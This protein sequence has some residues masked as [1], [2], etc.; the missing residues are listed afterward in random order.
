MVQE[1]FYKWFNEDYLRLYSYHN[2]KEAETHVDFVIKTSKLNEGSKIL[3]IGCGNGR[4]SI[5][6]AKRGYDVVGVDISNYLISDAKDKAN[7]LGIKN[8]QFIN[9]D[10]LKLNDISKFDLAINIFTS[11]GYFDSD[12]DN[13]KILTAIKSHLKPAGCLFLDYLHP[14]QVKKDLIPYETKM[15]AGELVEISKEIKNNTVIKK[16][17][18]PGRSY[19]ER[20]KL[21]DRFQ[22]EEMLGDNGF[23]IVEIYNDYKGNLWKENGDRQLFLA[24]RQN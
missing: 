13:A 8:V 10:I 15:V 12:F 1:W 24:K 20:V 6:L 5:S 16:I 19:E 9:D 21:Y 18:F 3:D 17:S 2:L 7:E 14:E 23:D 11:F 22:I 4:H